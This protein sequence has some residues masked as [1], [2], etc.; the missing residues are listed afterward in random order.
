MADRTFHMMKDGARETIQ[1]ARWKAGLS[2]R[3]LSVLTNKRV[4]EETIRN[5][6]LGVVGGH[7]PQTL[8]ILAQHLNLDPADLF[9]SESA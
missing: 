6:E 2:R 1:K 3:E 5:V 9:E 4:S 8:Y 7:R